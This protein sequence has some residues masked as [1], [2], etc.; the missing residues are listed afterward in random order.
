MKY[1]VCNQVE[2]QSAWFKS[3]FFFL[4]KK[5]MSFIVVVVIIIIIIVV[6]FL[7]IW[8]HFLLFNDIKITY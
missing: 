1:I 7:Y 3:F 5:I 2:L 4:I 8:L 6:Y